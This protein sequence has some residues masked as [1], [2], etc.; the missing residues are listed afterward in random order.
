VNAGSTVL[1]SS[2]LAQTNAGITTINVLSSQLPGGTNQI[3]VVYSGDANYTG[4]V[5]TLNILGPTATG[6]ALTPSTAALTVAQDTASSTVTLTATPTGGFNSTISF[7]CT[8][9]LPSGATCLFTPSVL[10]LT[11][12]AAA[13]TTLSIAL[14]A[15]GNKIP[16]TRARNDRAPGTLPFDTGA[17]F[18]GVILV[19]LPRRR[20]HPRSRCS[21]LVFLFAAYAFGF[22]AGCG[23]VS[24]ANEAGQPATAVGAYVITV[25]ATA[26]STIQATTITLTV[27]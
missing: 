27:Q 7:A 18:A 26:G 13:T 10:A 8:N 22:I 19:F 24:L 23:S 11:G 17:T 1:A 3:T 5:F 14:A 4:S 2:T 16:D 15:S 20:H 21:L 12:N 25:T 9:G 6:F